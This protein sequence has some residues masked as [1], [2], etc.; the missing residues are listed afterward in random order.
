M[1]KLILGLLL[2]AIL[3]SCDYFNDTRIC[4]QTGKEIVFKIT[5][6]SEVVK[7]WSGGMLVENVTQT[8]NNWDE[9][10]IPIEVD[11]VGYISTYLIKPNNCASIEGG[12]N[13]RPNFHFY[14]EL[15]IVADTDTIRLRTKEEM[16]RAFDADRENPEYYFDLLIYNSGKSSSR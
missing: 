4:N 5:F 11:T 2:S 7:N 3:I 6:D 8:F 13:R 16:K 12:N 9:N 10:L 1:K 15:E 14:K